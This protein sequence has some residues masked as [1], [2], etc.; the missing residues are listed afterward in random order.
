MKEK[1]TVYYLIHGYLA[2][3]SEERKKHTEDFLFLKG[4]WVKDEKT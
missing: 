4:K 1:K 3:K 2:A